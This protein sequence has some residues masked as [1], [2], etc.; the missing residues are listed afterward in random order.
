MG[1]IGRLNVFYRISVVSIYFYSPTYVSHLFRQ[2]KNNIQLY[3]ISRCSQLAITSLSIRHVYIECS[4][5]QIN[6]DKTCNLLYRTSSL[7]HFITLFPHFSC[8]I[9]RSRPVYLWNWVNFHRCYLMKFG[10]VQMT[11]QEKKNLLVCLSSFFC[12]NWKFI[13]QKILPH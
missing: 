11:N 5:N 8:T 2:P 6:S 3:S 12:P 1:S 7:T 10:V 9:Q 4:H 13:L